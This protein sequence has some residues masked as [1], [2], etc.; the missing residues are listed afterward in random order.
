VLKE[1]IFSLIAAGFAAFG[2]A[3]A[4][5]W[6]SVRQFEDREPPAGR[7][8]DP[9]TALVFMLVVGTAIVVSAAATYWCG[10]RGLRRASGIAGFGDTHA[11]AISAATLAASNKTSSQC[12]TLSILV[13][14][15][16]TAVSKSLVAFSLGHR[17]Y[18][19]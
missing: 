2:Y 4:F 5:A 19:L 17:Q 16:I 14:F 18:A 3:A 10:D 15:S 8:F 1:L 9:K 11:A 7:P 6:R 12:S 13:A